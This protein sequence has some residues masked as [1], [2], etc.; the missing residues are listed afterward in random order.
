MAQ[1]VRGK[2]ASARDAGFVH[3]VHELEDGY[4]TLEW[5]VKQPWSNGSVGQMGESYMGYTSLAS[6]ASKHPALKCTA[7]G[8][9]ST[10]WTIGLSYTAD[11]TH[12]FWSRAL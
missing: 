9:T 5:I 6:L 12:G 8:M 4:D 10:D 7:P 1:D 11:A 3:S 2:Y